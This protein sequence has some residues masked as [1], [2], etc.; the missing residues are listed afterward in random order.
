M[1]TKFICEEL[2]ISTRTTTD[3]ASLCRE[4]CQDIL[5]WWSGKIVGPGIVVEIDKRK[6][7]KRKYNRGKRVVGRWVFGGVERGTNNCFFAVVENRTS[8]VLLSVIEDHI[9]AGTTVMSDCWSS[10][11]CLSDE[12]FVHLTV[13]RSMYFVDPDT[14][15]HTSSIEAVVDYGIGSV[16]AH[17]QL[18]T[19]ETKVVFQCELKKP[20]SIEDPSCMGILHAKSY[21]VAKRSIVGVTWKFGEEV[22][23]HVSSSSSDRGSKLRGASQNSPCVASK[24]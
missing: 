11:Q 22:P 19:A 2:N 7:G 14:G 4:V 1:K 24:R 9:L 6:F 5:I 15:A 12:G 8:E 3:W 20:D 10:Y 21:V 17:H 23:A 13:N 16:S 18:Q